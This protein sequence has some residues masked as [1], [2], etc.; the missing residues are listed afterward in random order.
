MHLFHYQQRVRLKLW[1]WVFRTNVA[2]CAQLNIPFTTSCVVTQDTTAFGSD[3]ITTSMSVWNSNWNC[4]HRWCWGDVLVHT[5]L[6]IPDSVLCRV[7]SSIT[8]STRLRGYFRIIP[9][10]NQYISPV[11]ACIP[12]LTS[13][14]KERLPYSP[15][16][17]VSHHFRGCVVSWLFA[18]VHEPSVD[19]WCCGRFVGGLP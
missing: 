9:S 18:Y 5:V 10:C 13:H 4:L 6:L 19:P 8:E 2:E 17:A 3:T 14:T 16:F 15:I 11:W 12:K 7:T 1:R